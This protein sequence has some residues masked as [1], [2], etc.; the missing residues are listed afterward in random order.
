MKHTK[1][2]VNGSCGFNQMQAI[3]W[4]IGFRV[5]WVLEVKKPNSIH[6][7]RKIMDRLKRNWL[8]AKRQVIEKSKDKDKQKKINKINNKLY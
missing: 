5:D 6:F 3:L 8:L 7:N 1:S 4:K 2:Y